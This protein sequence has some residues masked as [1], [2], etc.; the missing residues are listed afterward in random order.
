[1]TIQSKPIPATTASAIDVAF[2]LG[3]DAY[4]AVCREFKTT[5][6]NCRL[7]L[8]G[9]DGIACYTHDA[10]PPALCMEGSTLRIRAAVTMLEAGVPWDRVA[11]TFGV[12]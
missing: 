4:A 3:C 2:L 9:I 5:T 11:E 12:V 7:V 6:V 8:G 1:M 10:V